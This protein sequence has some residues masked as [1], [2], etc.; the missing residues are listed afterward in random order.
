MVN[1]KPKRG[2]KKKCDSGYNKK[3]PLRVFTAFS[4]YDSQCMALDELKKVSDF[5]YELVGWSEIDKNA[6]IAHDALYPQYKDRN[7]GDISKVNWDEVPDFDFF[8]YSS[9]CFV[10]TTKINVKKHEND[11]FAEQVPIDEVQVGWFA[12]THEGRYKKITE[13]MSRP[14][15]G[16]IYT[17][18]NGGYDIVTCTKDHPFYCRRKGTTEW[19]WK[20]ACQIDI[21]NDE[22]KVFWRE[23]WDGQYYDSESSIN[24]VEIERLTSEIQVYNL[25]VEDDHSYV[26]NNYVVHNCTDF[27]P[28]GYQKGGDEGSGTRSSLLWECRRA[29]L[30]KKPKYL[31]FEHVKALVSDKFVHVFNKWCK[32]LESYGYV[33]FYQ[34]LNAK[35]YGV[36]QNRERIFMISILKDENDPNPY[37][38]FPQ[39]IKLQS[40]VHDILEKEVDE[41][42]YRRIK[43]Q[44]IEK[45]VKHFQEDYP[46]DDG[47]DTEGG[48]GLW[49]T[50]EDKSNKKLIMCEYTG[51]GKNDP[52][53]GS[54]LIK[55][56]NV[57]STLTTQ[58]HF[59]KVVVEITEY[60]KDDEK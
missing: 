55:G 30:A 48:E 6:I 37:Y 20:M 53:E 27:S 41:K 7:Y 11:E 54:H 24:N 25:E 31:F 19:E 10:G 13:V 60:N 12:L 1:D 35:D 2:R 56:G 18:T 52:R 45:Y 23:K 8:T 5:D 57:A 34:V 36:P 58:S 14:Y 9:P 29:I 50:N 15:K 17:I 39:K 51:Y 59:N 40:T 43:P 28:A 3:N 21:E 32:E 33:N 42:Y 16:L 46:K 4:G 26:A 38:E 49:D 44:D 22:V 47:L